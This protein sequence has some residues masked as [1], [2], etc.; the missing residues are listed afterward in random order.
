MISPALESFMESIG[1]LK[2]ANRAKNIQNVALV[3]EDVDEKALLRRYEREL[4]RLRAELSQRN[5]NVVDKRKLI[6]MEEMRNRAERDKMTALS[7][8]EK[9]SHDL[10]KAKEDKRILIKK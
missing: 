4:K 3:N 10:I 6:E 2:F 7:T 1:T 8:L 9:L 5:K